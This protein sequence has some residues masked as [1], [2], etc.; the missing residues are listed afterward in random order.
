[1][2]SVKSL[3]SVTKKEKIAIHSPSIISKAVKETC[4]AR[5][6]SLSVYL[7]NDVGYQNHF[8]FIL[9]YEIK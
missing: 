4:F 7:P 6:L 3:R 5:S 2:P 1:M 9:S 8:D